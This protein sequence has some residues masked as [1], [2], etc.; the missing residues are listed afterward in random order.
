MI[1]ACTG[2]TIGMSG[3]MAAEGGGGGVVGFVQRHLPLR[4]EAS[5]GGDPPPPPPLPPGALRGLLRKAPCRA[6]E[7]G[8][9]EAR[10]AERTGARRADYW[11]GRGNGAERWRG[12]VTSTRPPV[13]PPPTPRAHTQPSR[14]QHHARSCCLA[15][16]ADRTRGVQRD[17]DPRTETCTRYSC[18]GVEPGGVGSDPGHVTY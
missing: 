18:T 4:G 1:E 9:A 7:S 12:E 6:M 10:A 17:E 16:G 11:S 3:A 15:S 13:L 2:P 8:A 5:W 14:R